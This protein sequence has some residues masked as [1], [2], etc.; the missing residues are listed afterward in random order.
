MNPGKLIIFSA[1]SGSGKSTIVNHLIDRGMPIEFSISACSRQP[2]GKE[3]DGEHYYFLSPEE[4]KAKVEQDEFLEWE[5]VYEGNYYGTLRSEVDRIWAKGKHVIFDIDVVGG[6]NLKKQFGDHAL[7]VFIKAPSIDVLKKRLM[8]RNTESSDQLKMR[9]DKAEE[10][11]DY[12][13]DFDLII[14]NDD[15]KTAQ[16]EA[17]KKVSQFING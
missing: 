11:M 17:Y 16:E 10:E 8:I 14:T 6:L 3:K 12:A 13:K 9:L 2:R 7:S 1:P 4:F 5:E 15:L